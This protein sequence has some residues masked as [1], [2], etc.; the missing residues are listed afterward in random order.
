MGHTTH[1]L[2]LAPAYLRDLEA[3]K[4]R[5]SGEPEIISDRPGAVLWDGGYLP[6]LWLTA[7]AVD[8]G[9][10]RVRQQGVVV[11]SIRRSHHIGCL[12]VFL[13]RATEAGC[14]AI[15][16]CSD[17]SVATVAP[18]GGT[19]PLYTP[20]PIAIGVPTDGD[21]ILIDVSASITTN[22][23]TGRLHREGKKLEHEW[24]LDADGN[25]SNDPAVLFTTPPGTILPTGGLDHGH[26]GYGL[27]LTVEALTQ[28]LSGHGRADAPTQWGAS[29]FVQIVDP[30]AFGGSAAFL[31][32]SSWLAAACRANPPRPG[33]PPVRLPGDGAAIKARAAAKDGL[34]LYPA[35][36]D[37][38]SPWADK[39]GVAPPK[40]NS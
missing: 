39:F 7:K 15:V 23:Y 16:S 37:G 21:P 17:P 5:G 14:L 1:G 33:L 22:G 28:A 4:M 36:L 38:L 31:R 26:K 24:L 40:A 6:G 8:L 32:Q 13:T 2:A 34:A 12:A 29:T 18:F 35:I 27:A 19:K 30:E 25:P 3:G 9:L 10:A 20:D 11:I